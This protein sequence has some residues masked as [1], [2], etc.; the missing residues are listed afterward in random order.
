MPENRIYFHDSPQPT[1]G[2]EV[3]LLLVDQQSLAL[4]P[5]APLILKEF[6][7]DDHVKQELLNSIVEVITGICQNVA[8]VREDLKKTIKKVIKKAEENGWYVL[9]MG[10]HPFSRW[11]DQTITDMERYIHLI[12]RFQWPARRLLITG[13]HVHVGVES[14]EKSIA[15]TNGMI[16]YIPH[17]IGLSS[18]SPILDGEI[19]GLASTR[20]KLFE[21]M[22]T[23][24]L[25]HVLRN[26]SEFQK[27]MRILQKANTI[28]SIREVW[29]DIR[30]HPGFGT[31]ESRAFDAVPTLNEM[32][33]LAAFTQCLVVAISDHYDNGAQLPVMERWING[34]NKWRA[35]RYG[36][37]AE[38]IVDERGTLKSLR[39]EILETLE[40]M[41]PVARKLECQ[42]EML[43][44]HDMVLNNRV[45]YQRQLAKF[46]DSKDLKSII[47]DSVS[48]LKK[49][50]GLL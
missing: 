5:G 47:S 11:V 4:H 38:I 34:E 6:E 48:A 36:L 41:L 16:R 13:E 43:D 32:V 24:G 15:I 25:P 21:G 46:K 33:N 23:T 30:P 1:L 19:S 31:V 10:T 9:S 49:S 14:A 29:W 22:P 3:E 2:V 17:M 40:K 7:N 18:N 42:A 12:E 50:V 8:E 28:E 20:T 45:P 27:F 39:T 37:D 26:Y 44:L 35:T